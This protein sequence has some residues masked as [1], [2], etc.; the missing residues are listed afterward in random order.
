MKLSQG[1]LSSFF[2]VD[3]Q[4]RD[5]SFFASFMKPALDIFYQAQPLCVFAHSANEVEELDSVTAWLGIELNQK[6]LHQ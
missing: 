4:L 2:F 3:I 6:V 5:L 1:V